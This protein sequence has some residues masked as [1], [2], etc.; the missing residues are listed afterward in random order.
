MRELNKMLV[1]EERVGAIEMASGA[2]S[3]GCS[4]YGCG[5]SKFGED[6]SDSSVCGIYCEGNEQ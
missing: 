4:T 2:E 1:F 3:C 6:F 5:C